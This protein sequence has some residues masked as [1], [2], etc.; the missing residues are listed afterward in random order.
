M[1]DT[2]VD[3]YT[4]VVDELQTDVDEIEASV[5]SPARTNDSE[6]I[7]TLKREIAE[8]RRAV[9]P[10]RDPI[11]RFADGLVKGMAPEGAPF[12]RDVLDHLNQAAE[13]VHDLDM[14]LSTAFEAHLARISVQQNN[15]VRKISAGVAAVAV[16]TLIAGV[17][18]MNFEHMPELSWMLGYPFALLLMVV[19][20]VGLLVWFK[21]SGWL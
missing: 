3:G 21:K 9:M 12:F 8:V 1:C 17:Y 15:D 13:V 6:R 11:R 10:L 18:G 5:F 20:S 2:V 4:A 14:L 16:S 19:S 7:Y